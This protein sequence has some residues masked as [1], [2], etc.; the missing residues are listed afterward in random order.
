MK[1]RLFISTILSALIMFLSLFFTANFSAGNDGL[2]ILLILF[3]I[4][5]PILSAA[6]GIV[7]GK[8]FKKLFFLPILNG[9]FFLSSAWIFLEAFELQFFSYTA[10]YIIIGLLFS[11]FTHLIY[12]RK[13]KN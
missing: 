3:F 5:Y 8:F 12:K 4:A 7:S 11:F 13:C 10:A 6:I 1:I 9:I 2:G